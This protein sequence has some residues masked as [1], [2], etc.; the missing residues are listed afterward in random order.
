MSSHAYSQIYLHITFHTKDNRPMI[1]GEVER[2]LHDYLRTRSLENCRLERTQA[3]VE[4][5]SRVTL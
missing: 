4:S 2:H 3:A 5:A 1:R